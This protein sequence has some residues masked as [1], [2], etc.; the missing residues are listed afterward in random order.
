MSQNDRVETALRELITAYDRLGGSLY[1]LSDKG[2]D[3]DAYYTPCESRLMDLCSVLG[4]DH[5]AIMAE[6]GRSKTERMHMDVNPVFKGME[7]P[8]FAIIAMADLQDSPM[9]FIRLERLLRDHIPR[10]EL[11][12][13]I[14]GLED[15]DI[16]RGEWTVTEDGHW[17]RLYHVP[18]REIANGRI[19]DYRDH[20]LVTEVMDRV[21]EGE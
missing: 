19:H 4:Y 20:P 10:R 16:V 5:D 12:K 21:T 8:V 14:D 13:I 3:P 9:Y 18:S 1:P 6:N 7:W 11:S 17:R 2:F 15:H